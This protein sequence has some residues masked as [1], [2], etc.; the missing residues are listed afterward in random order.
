MRHNGIYVIFLSLPFV[1][2]INKR[3][4][5]FVV[6]SI[7]GVA[8]VYLLVGNVLYPALHITSGSR[9]EAL[10]IPLQ[11][12]GRYIY[13]NYDDITDDERAVLEKVIDIEA[14]RDYYSPRS[15]DP[16]KATFNENATNSELMDYFVLWFKMFFKHPGC[17]FEALINNTYGY[18]YY[19]D[20][21]AWKYTM[22]ES[23][24][25]QGIINPAGFNIHHIESLHS[26]Q[27]LFEEYEELLTHLPVVSILCSCAFF[28]WLLIIAFMVMWRKNKLKYIFLLMP[29]IVSLLVC[30]A[31]PYNGIDDFRYMFPIAFV[32]PVVV[33]VECKVMRENLGDL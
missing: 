15:A 2:L 3:H 26:L 13:E 4:W 20:A 16:V 6:S 27:T 32:L 14:C 18:F 10:S 21:P 23:E 17:Y 25:V 28:S 1:V 30:I 8:V 22:A 5:K 11:Q 29:S 12:T 9:R 31:S 33:A 24:N 7:I 19:G